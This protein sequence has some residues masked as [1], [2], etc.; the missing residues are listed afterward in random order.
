MMKAILLR[1]FGPA[2]NL[3]VAQLLRVLLRYFYLFLTKLY[4]K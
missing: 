2:Q 3:F 1:G 4:V